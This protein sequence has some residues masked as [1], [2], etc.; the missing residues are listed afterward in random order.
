METRFSAIGGRGLRLFLFWVIVIMVV[1]VDQATKAAAV[2]VL[3]DGRGTLIPGVI[4]LVHV[5]NTGA[6]FS[7]GE[8]AGFLFVLV[9]LAFLVGACLFVWHED[10]LPLGIVA[11]VGLVAGGGLGNMIDRLMNGSVTDFLATAFMKFP[12]FNVADMCVTVG[13]VCA[14]VGYWVWD[15]RREEEQVS[16]VDADNKRNASHA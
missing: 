1:L 11:S 6:A 15:A 7:I 3:G 16:S 2:E 9:A 8:G 10:K 12:V 13:V 5:E 4:D 14:V